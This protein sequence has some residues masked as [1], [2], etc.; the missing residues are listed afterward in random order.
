MSASKQILIIG[1]NAAL[2]HD[3]GAMLWPAGIEARVVD[4][5]DFGLLDIDR[6]RRNIEILAPSA[7]TDRIEHGRTVTQARNHWAVGDLAEV[8]GQNGI[9]LLHLSSDQVFA[10]DR[11]EPYLE[12]DMPDANSV[13]GQSQAAGEAEIRAHC[14]HHVIVRSGWLFSAN[15]HNML[16]TMISLGR[17]GGRVHVPHDHVSGPT[18]VRELC[19]A[20]RQ[21][22]LRMLETPAECGGHTLHFCG[23]PAATLYEFAEVAISRAASFQ[24][25]PDLVPIT[26]SRFGVT[27]APA[28][29][30]ELD[31]TT[32]T[33][34]FGLT[35]PDWRKALADCVDEICQTDGGTPEQRIAALAETPLPYRGF[36]PEN[37]RRGALPYGVA[38]DRRRAG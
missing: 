31:C 19:A 1:R 38:T 15:G 20:L 24:A 25:S 3:L 37:R 8:A 9:P 7:S 12:T 34:Q 14:R 4:G 23:A 27:G 28:R 21:I 29:R 2:A 16:R 6:L 36:V 5:A 10:G 17:R 35:Q 18:P 33:A 22:A 30:T 13:L 32:A 26:P 11:Q